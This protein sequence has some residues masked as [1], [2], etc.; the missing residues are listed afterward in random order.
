MQSETRLREYLSGEQK[1]LAELS[2]QLQA[3]ADRIAANCRVSEEFAFVD[4]GFLDLFWRCWREHLRPHT[5]LIFQGLADP[6]KAADSLL[7]QTLAGLSRQVPDLAA[8]QHRYLQGQRQ[9]AW[10]LSRGLTALADL[11]AELARL[12]AAKLTPTGLNPGLTSD[13]KKLQELIPPASALA[14]AQQ[15]VQKL[16]QKR[17]CH[18]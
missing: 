3:E 9:A 8:A 15:L 11:A 17:C 18:D 13:L 14:A 6:D 16:G 10:D 4:P 5:F 2:R 7:L 12:A 1:L